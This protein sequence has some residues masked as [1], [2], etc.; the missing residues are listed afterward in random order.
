MKNNNKEPNKGC[1]KQFII[2]MIGMFL[3][4][5]PLNPFFEVGKG[6]RLTASSWLVTM[7]MVVGLIWFVVKFFGKEK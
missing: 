7:I 4:A 6:D 3:I 1:L 2:F 5:S